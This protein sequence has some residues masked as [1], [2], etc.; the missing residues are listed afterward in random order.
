MKYRLA[1]LGCFAV[2]TSDFREL[3]DTALWDVPAV[4]A[5]LEPALL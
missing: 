5:S 4:G 1:L 3:D 2:T